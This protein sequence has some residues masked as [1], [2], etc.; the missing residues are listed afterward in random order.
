MEESCTCERGGNLLPSRAPLLSR[1][2]PRNCSSL[3][4]KDI[5]HLVEPLFKPESLTQADVGASGAVFVVV[6]VT[7]LDLVV[8]YQVSDMSIKTL[9]ISPPSRLF[10]TFTPSTS[11]PPGAPL[12]LF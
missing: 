10:F 5:G 11:T 9:L 1:F 7:N 2:G 6:A 4:G 12:F 3:V 8:I